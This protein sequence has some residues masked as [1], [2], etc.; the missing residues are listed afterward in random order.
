M[1]LA[2]VATDPSLDP[3]D[4][5]FALPPLDGMQ[6]PVRLRF[7]FDCI[8]AFADGALG[9]GLE[10]G[11]YRGCSTVVLAQ[12]ARQ[13]GFHRVTA[14]DLFT[15]TPGWG[16]TFDTEADCRTRLQRFG[17]ADLVQLVRA[18]SAALPWQQPLALLH[19]DG[20]HSHQAVRRDIERYLPHLV[21][22][23]IVVFDDYDAAHPGVVAAVHELL[24]AD[25]ALLVVACNNHRPDTGSICVQRRR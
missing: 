24:A 23:G 12:A 3:P 13:R 18:D 6:D 21:P 7:L 17:V 8:V 2:A 10:I 16:Q 19:V 14:I 5:P 15:G 1:R 9:E 4:L 22:G 20:D 11:C 25:P